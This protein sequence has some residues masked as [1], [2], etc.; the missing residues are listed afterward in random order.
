MAW[1]CFQDMAEPKTRSE[2]G[3]ESWPIVKLSGAL[4]VSFC[5][6]CERVRLIAR[7]YGTTCPHCEG[8]DSQAPLTPL[9]EAG[10]ARISALQELELAWRESEADLSLISCAWFANYDPES[11]TWRTSQ[12]SLILDLERFSGPWPRWGTI[13]G[14]L[15]YQQQRLEPRTCENESGLLPTATAT[16]Y[17]SNQSMSVNAKVRHSLQSLARKGLLPTPTVCGN[18]NRKG[19]SAKSGDGLA[20]A[21]ERWPTP[22]ARDWKD[23]LTPKR[24]GRHSPSVAVAVAVAEKGHHGFLSPLFV[25]AIMGLPIGATE[26]EPL[27]TV[28]CLKRRAK[29]SKD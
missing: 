1:I 12:T 3:S 19:A 23:G 14:G 17:G 21:L 16:E 10:L 13:S 15:A 24:H 29:R 8:T 9:P 28:G 20:T 4:S 18:Y 22:A 7:R 5:D 11:S 27:A 26:L 2:N 6:G 25:E